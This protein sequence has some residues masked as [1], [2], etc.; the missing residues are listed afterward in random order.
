MS[1]GRKSC[2]AYPVSASPWVRGSDT[3]DF[4]TSVP[5]T[6]ENN[7]GVRLASVV[8]EPS[9]RHRLDGAHTAPGDLYGQRRGRT[10]TSRTTSSNEY[11]FSQAALSSR[12]PHPPRLD[13]PQSAFFE[14]PAERNLPRHNFKIRHRSYNGILLTP[15]ESG[16]LRK[17][18]RTVE[19]S[20]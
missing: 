16:L 13:F 1:A 3:K 19:Q 6:R 10:P 12:R 7:P 18:S 15:E 8:T 2:L 20:S 5:G 14:A 11:F 4:S 17:A 9:T